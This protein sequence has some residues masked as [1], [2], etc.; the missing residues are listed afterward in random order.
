MGQN[1]SAAPE[2]LTAASVITPSRIDDLIEEMVAFW[3]EGRTPDTRA[4]L[5]YHPEQTEGGKGEGKEGERKPRGKGTQ[6]K[7][8]DIKYRVI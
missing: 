3:K 7:S 8:H 5:E 2:N 6:V 4:F 1:P